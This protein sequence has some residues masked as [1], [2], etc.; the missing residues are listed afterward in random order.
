MNVPSEKPDVLEQQ[1]RDEARGINTN[2]TT[3]PPTNAPTEA[4]VTTVADTLHAQQDTVEQLEADLEQAQAIRDQYIESTAKP[5]Y[6]KVRDQAYSTHGKNNDKILDYNLSKAKEPTG[7]PPQTPTNPTIVQSNDGTAF[8]VTWKKVTKAKTYEVW[9]GV[10]TNAADDQTVPNMSF[11]DT[12]TKTSYTH[13]GIAKGSR[14]F[15]GT[16]AVNP[17]GKSELSATQSRV[18]N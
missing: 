1:L 18:A 5:M 15:Y 2:V 9:Y 6:V 7:E 4:E 14:Y 3:W 13:I 11:L 8:I 16:K 10:S 12:S 17:N